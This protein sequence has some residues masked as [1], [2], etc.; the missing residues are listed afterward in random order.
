MHEKMDSEASRG[1]RA[2]SAGAASKRSHEDDFEPSPGLSASGTGGSAASSSKQTRQA[3]PLSA[4]RAAE[5]LRSLVDGS[6]TRQGCQPNLVSISGGKWT[7]S[8]SEMRELFL[9]YAE[10]VAA[11]AELDYCEVPT[12]N[13]VIRLDIDVQ[14]M[15]EELS[16]DG[17]QELFTLGPEL[18]YS[19]A[20]LERLVVICN[21]LL[22]EQLFDC[23][24][25]L[26]QCLVLTKPARAEIVDTEADG[27]KRVRRLVC[28]IH[29]MW[30]LLCAG[31][32]EQRAWAGEVARAV[33]DDGLFSWC[34]KSPIDMMS[35][36]VPWLLYGGRKPSVTR[37]EETIVFQ[38]YEITGARDVLGNPVDSEE[39][40]DRVELLNEVTERPHRDTNVFQRMTIRSAGRRVYSLRPS[41]RHRIVAPVARPVG[42]QQGV[43]TD[44]SLET[45]TGLVELL[46]PRRAEAYGDWIDVG[47]CLA[48]LTDQ[49][50]EG[51]E[52]F[53][54]FSQGCPYKY[55]EVACM[56]KWQGFCKR[57]RGIG[58]LVSWAKQD[59]PE[60]YQAWS[61]RQ[62]NQQ[63]ANMKRA[64]SGELGNLAA[65]MLQGRFVHSSDRWFE[66]R[67]PV[68]VDLAKKKEGTIPIKRELNGPLKLQLEQFKLQLGREKETEGARD[69]LEKVIC[70]LDEPGGLTAVVDMLKM[71]MTERDFCDEL[72]QNPFLIGV[73]NGVVDL[74][75]GEFR[76]GRPEDKIS[77]TFNCSYQ[78]YESD[79]AEM[80]AMNDLW[81]KMF[82]QDDLREYMINILSQVFVG[83]MFLKNIFFWI[84][85]GDN[86]KTAFGRL[87]QE[88]L[89]PNF[90][91]TLP[92]S[93]L[94][95]AK[96]EA[97]RAAPE[98]AGIRGKKM[99]IFGEPER[100]ETLSNGIIKSLTGKDPQYARE[101]FQTGADVVAFVALCIFIFIA[102]NEPEVK[103]NSDMALWARVVVCPFYSKF[104]DA[105]LVPESVEE[106]FATRTFLKDPD[107]MSGL[108]KMAPVLFY[109]LL[110]NWCRIKGSLK[111]I[112]VPPC[113]VKANQSYK[114]RNDQVRMFL[115][116]WCEQDSECTLSMRDFKQQFDLKVKKPMAGH[117]L[118]EEL[119]KLA[120]DVADNSLQGWRWQSIV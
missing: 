117:R 84:G 96:Q 99:V 5:I 83:S 9:L 27:R 57:D 15:A 32:A 63:F 103:N 118:I 55:S 50:R 48:S 49:S 41:E 110:Q 95:G 31:Q 73:R 119:R 104:T 23:D 114:E 120:V 67:E 112:K 42:S 51:L 76:E 54:L 106:Q 90:F 33:K 12:P 70:K 92:T 94:T 72:D 43:R 20:E 98:I 13:S 10:A 45:L 44:V 111:E 109:F 85:T 107:F 91:L 77:M 26:I 18:V 62:R 108:E 116:E 14:R 7:L 68:W 75:T 30:P 2:S 16:D 86:G 52:L 8:S 21:G 47:R 6:V 93:V 71:A 1:T 102:N 17:D 64:T 24:P 25:E 58:L 38:P 39:L 80:L 28:G 105:E 37:G 19:Q 53:C 4:E 100:E 65:K 87:F 89:G 81:R 35:S 79:S 88:M 46:S 22:A 97:G 56:S 61:Q 11:G 60:R 66:F 40:L 36:V 74:K 113:V 34:S 3:A 78:V 115:D 101:L 82:V 29:L 59:N 69:F